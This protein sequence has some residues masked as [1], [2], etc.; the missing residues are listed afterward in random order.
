MRR[1]VARGDEG[2]IESLFVTVQDF[3]CIQENMANL[4]NAASSLEVFACWD[5]FD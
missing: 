4:L 1:I 5:A 3:L 2:N